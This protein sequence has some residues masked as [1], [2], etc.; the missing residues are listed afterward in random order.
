VKCRLISCA[1]E[2]DDPSG[3]CLK[4]RLP[5]VVEVNISRRDLDL[6]PGCGDTVRELLK[7]ADTVELFFAAEDLGWV[8]ATLSPL[9]TGLSDDVKLDEEHRDAGTFALALRHGR[10]LRP[11]NL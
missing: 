5:L 4:H 10:G 7:R 11:G 1:R 2:T 9:H 3:F 6:I 8:R